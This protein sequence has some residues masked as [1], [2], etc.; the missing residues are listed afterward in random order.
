M[1][2]F[3][4]LMLFLASYLPCSYGALLY[5]LISCVRYF[6][7]KKSAKNIK[8]SNNK[9]LTFTLLIFLFFAILQ[10]TYFVSKSM[11]D[12][13]FS[14]FTE[15]CA[16]PEKEPRSYSFFNNIVLQMPNLFSI[17]SLMVDMKIILFLK[18]IILP[19]NNAPPVDF[20]GKNFINF[21][22]FSRTDLN[23]SS[24][25]CIFTRSTF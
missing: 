14:F 1:N 19:T 25:A 18:R 23:Y 8:P 16:Y 2:Y 10:A 17:I 7:A 3:P 13:P 4:C 6:L 24:M 22:A 21:G 9:V 5:L 20:Q 11:L 15:A 12:I